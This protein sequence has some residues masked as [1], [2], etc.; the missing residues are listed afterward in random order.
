MP[1]VQFEF[2]NF[3]NSIQPQ[4]S[5]NWLTTVV[6]QTTRLRKGGGSIN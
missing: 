1:W 3:I 4:M 2:L 6:V 5:T